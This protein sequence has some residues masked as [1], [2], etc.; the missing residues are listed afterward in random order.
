MIAIDRAVAMLERD[1]PGINIIWFE[2]S[3][4]EW[5]L[6]KDI[7]RHLGLTANYLKE[8]FAPKACWKDSRYVDVRWAAP[9]VVRLESLYSFLVTRVEA[10]RYYTTQFSIDGEKVMRVVLNMF[11]SREVAFKFWTLKT[12]DYEGYT[13]AACRKN[14]HH[15]AQ[16]NRNITPAG[17]KVLVP[18]V[19]PGWE[20]PLVYIV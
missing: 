13:F 18:N 16:A 6:L 12:T 7:A 1:I 11:R 2:G 14:I 20:S 17:F 19:C 9:L 10:D 3:K 5:V 8:Q 4:T 15:V